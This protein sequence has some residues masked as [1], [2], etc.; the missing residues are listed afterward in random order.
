LWTF[1]AGKELTPAKVDFAFNGC[2]VVAAAQEQ[3]F[4]TTGEYIDFVK[5]GLEG[6]C[7]EVRAGWMKAVDFTNAKKLM[8]AGGTG[9]LLVWNFQTQTS[10]TALDMKVERGLEIL[11][12]ALSADGSLVAA[13]AGDQ[14]IYVWSTAG[15]EP[16]VTLDGHLG[17]LT[18]LA[19]S[20]DGRF[21]FSSSEDGTILVWGVYP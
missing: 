5:N 17:K 14:R 9:K 16:L 2:K 19:F 21:L 3:A 6:L 13:A 7:D 1:P 4:V 20:P 11:E 10:E 12:A 18:G 8:A 15:G